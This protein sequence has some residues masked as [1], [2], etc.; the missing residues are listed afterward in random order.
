MEQDI[1]RRYTGVQEM[2][3]DYAIG[4]A[5]LGLFQRF[6]T[7]V[8]VIT[9]VL[10]AKMVWDIARKWCFALSFN[11]I[12]VLGLSANTIGAC[13]MALLAWVTIEF[14]G[15]VVPGVESISLS[16]ALMSGSWTLGASV[17]TFLMNGFLHRHERTSVRMN[18]A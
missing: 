15:A 7:P 17:N 14:L 16:A 4:L 9:V 18:D 2:V 1:L 6:L 11:P 3:V 10:V 12:A 13:A 5:I 8:L